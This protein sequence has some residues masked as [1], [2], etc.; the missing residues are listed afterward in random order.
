MTK[1]RSASTSESS[2]HDR[3]SLRL[4]RDGETTS[5]STK[6]KRNSLE[7]ESFVRASPRL[8]VAKFSLNDSEI[9][10]KDTFS[11]HKKYPSTP[12]KHFTRSAKRITSPVCLLRSDKG[13]VV[14]SQSPTKGRKK[15]TSITDSPEILIP[16]IEICTTQSQS[17][18]RHSS[19]L[20]ENGQSVHENGNAL[21]NEC[22]R[23]NNRT[24]RRRRC[25]CGGICSPRA[26]CAGRPVTRLSS[27]GREQNVDNNLSS[28]SGIKNSIEPKTGVLDAPPDGICRS[29]GYMQKEDNHELSPH[30]NSST[31][32]SVY[33]GTAEENL[34]ILEE[35]KDKLNIEDLLEIEYSDIA[36]NDFVGF[37]ARRKM[38]LRSSGVHC[39]PNYYALSL[40]LLK[41]S[42]SKSVASNSA[43]WEDKSEEFPL[44]ESYN[45]TSKPMLI[46]NGT[47]KKETK[48]DVSAD[49][50]PTFLTSSKETEKSSGRISDCVRSSSDEMHVTQDNIGDVCNLDVKPV[51]DMPG[52]DEATGNTSCENENG[53]AVS[54]V[55][56]G[57]E[58]IHSS[59]DFECSSEDLAKDCKLT[60]EPH[61]SLKEEKIC[62]NDIHETASAKQLVTNN[63]ISPSSKRRRGNFKQRTKEAVIEKPKIQMLFRDPDEPPPL[64]AEEAIPRSDV[65]YFESDHVALKHNKDYQGL[66]KTVVLLEAQRHQCLH[67]IES[68]RLEKNAAVAKPVAYVEK[69]QTN[70][71]APRSCQP[72]NVATL[73]NINWQKYS[74]QYGTFSNVFGNDSSSSKPVTRNL[75]INFES[76]VPEQSLST[77]K[78]TSRTVSPQ[79][80][81]ITWTVDEQLKL[82]ELL[83]KFPSEPVEFNRFRK[84]AAALGNRT[85]LQVQ[86]RVQKYFIKLARLGLPVP[87]V[88][89]R[90]SRRTRD[91]VR[92]GQTKRART[93]PQQSYLRASTFFPQL[94]C[95]VQMT[96]DHEDIGLPSTS[97]VCAS[98]VPL[99]QTSDDEDIPEVLRD[100]TEY[101][102]ILRLKKLRK[103][104][105]NISDDSV[106]QT[107]ARH[108]GYSCDMC[109]SDPIMGVRYHCIDC[110]QDTCVDL[111]QSCIHL[112]GQ[113]VTNTHK[114]SHRM[115]PVYESQNFLD[116]DYMKFDS[117]SG[118]YNY[119]DPNFHPASI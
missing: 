50:A 17:R 23:L 45:Q 20:Q 5:G 29:N 66:L 22:K 49:T 10:K 80:G 59:T 77:D 87:G 21:Q 73:S 14:F 15:S 46:E 93:H 70:H 16:K 65:Y 1:T 85:P 64:F 86:S 43:G 103:S 8:K 109:D 44:E 27:S 62:Q 4:A 74:S 34:S 92:F 25:Q 117:C 28:F 39:D 48:T 89:P 113:F 9:N 37:Q 106:R 76:G 2:V 107:L 95:P 90:S 75:K 116:G 31:S 96:S 3:R 83:L 111:C 100:S 108:M 19:L 82:A 6:L 69:L 58:N 7:L 105:L 118:E 104:K 84:I 56:C 11:P 112:H 99:E 30:E 52:E 72:Q 114:P 101:I 35:P 36:S 97:N 51:T 119:L 57:S 53:L 71:L 47:F 91:N 32:M 12:S 26:C 78:E 61:E 41:K 68:L 54:Q 18:L 81:R 110:P 63:Q 79:S 33:P 94:H 40:E 115:E 98:D 67:D 13:N 38:N 102:E 42:R 88:M 24:L 60:I 55:Q